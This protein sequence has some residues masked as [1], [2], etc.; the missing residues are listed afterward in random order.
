MQD[1]STSFLPSGDADSSICEK[2]LCVFEFRL[3]CLTTGLTC[4]NCTFLALG[5]TKGF[6]SL[7][8]NVEVFVLHYLKLSC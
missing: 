1:F 4:S 2:C 8:N 6:N 3:G 5:D 7:K